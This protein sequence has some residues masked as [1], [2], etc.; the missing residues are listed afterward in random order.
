[1]MTLFL[2]ACVINRYINIKE[3]LIDYDSPQ[4]FV[5]Y[6]KENVQYLCL[7]VEC[8]ETVQI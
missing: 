3:T 2:D 5:V 1:M 8:T 4:L 6:D 7:L